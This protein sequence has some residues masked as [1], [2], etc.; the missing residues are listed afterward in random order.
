MRLSAARVRGNEAYHSLVDQ[1][2]WYGYRV[3]KEQSPEFR[4]ELCHPHS[5]SLGHYR[6]GSKQHKH[7]EIK[8]HSQLHLSAAA[9]NLV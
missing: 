8:A 2:H 7:G 3:P 4:V 5:R 9:S 1:E 6:H